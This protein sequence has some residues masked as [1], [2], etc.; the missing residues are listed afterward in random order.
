MSTTRSTLLFVI[1][2]LC[3]CAASAQDALTREDLKRQKIDLNAD[4][5]LGGLFE[6]KGNARELFE[7]AAGY[8]VFSATKAGFGLTGGRGTGVV[9]D[10]A[11]GKRTYM[12][13]ATGGIGFGI[14]AQQYDLV[15]LFEHEQQLDRFALG[16]WDASTTAQAAAGTDGLSFMSSFVNGVALYQIT[17]RGLMAQADVSGTRFW[18]VDDLNQGTVQQENVLANSP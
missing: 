10:K 9:V 4:E 7:K 5:A 8:A 13:M 3:V 1:A 12:R 17:D 15:L 14:G 11:T 18:I 16:G 6:Q 2:S